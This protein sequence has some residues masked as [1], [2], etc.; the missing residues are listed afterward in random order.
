MDRLTRFLDLWFGPSD[1][2]VDPVDRVEQVMRLNR[3]AEPGSFDGE[4][5]ILVV[6]GQG[7]W[8]WGRHPDGRCVE[9]E[10]APGRDWRETGET[11]DQFWLHAAAVEAAFGLPATRSA[12]LL[13]SA[14]VEVIERATRRLPCRVWTWPA[15]RQRVHHRGASVVMVCDDDDA[16]WV[17]ASAPTEGELDWLDDLHLT[18]DEHDSRQDLDE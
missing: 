14:A 8:L 17:I 16:F 13:T 9:R 5:E 2:H 1:P 10:N 12:Q 11:V 6:E 4:V 3:R 15:T 18:W 7:V